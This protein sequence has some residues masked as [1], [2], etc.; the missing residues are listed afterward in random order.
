M[1]TKNI[2]GGESV[3]GGYQ[4]KNSKQ[5][6]GCYHADLNP[7]LLLWQEFLETRSFHSSSMATYTLLQMVVSLTNVNLLQNSN[8]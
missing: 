8:S 4:E 1:K 6:Q 2:G 7:C 3:M 5:R